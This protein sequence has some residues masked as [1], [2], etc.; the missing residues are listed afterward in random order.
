MR[1]G[2]VATSRQFVYWL[3][4][5][6]VVELVDTQASK[7]CAKSVRVRDPPGAPFF[8]NFFYEVC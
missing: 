2:R 3:Q 1:M 5:A 4:V 7:P 6:L 8:L